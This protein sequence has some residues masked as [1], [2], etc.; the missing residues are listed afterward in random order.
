MPRVMG[1][2]PSMSGEAGQWAYMLTRWMVRVVLGP[3]SLIWRNERGLV[4]R[5]WPGCLPVHSGWV[6]EAM[7]WWPSPSLQTSSTSLLSPS[8]TD[9]SL[10]PSSWTLLLLHLIRCWPAPKAVDIGIRVRGFLLVPASGL[11]LPAPLASAAGSLSHPASSFC[12][13][14]LLP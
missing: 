1:V 11:D 4:V 8:P 10:L 7:S 12:P 5:P 9:F 2:V 3:E 13:P 14:V 6:I